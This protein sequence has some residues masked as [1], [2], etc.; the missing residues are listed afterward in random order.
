MTI[1]FMYLIVNGKML[2]FRTR[3]QH[4]NFPFR[5]LGFN[6]L[7]NKLQTELVELLGILSIQFMPHIFVCFCLYIAVYVFS[8]LLHLA[9]V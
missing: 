6:L 5:Y 8:I 2:T 7:L 4:I 3:I 9:I 1:A